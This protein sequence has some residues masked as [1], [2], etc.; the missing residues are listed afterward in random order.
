MCPAKVSLVAGGGGDGDGGAGAGGM[1]PIQSVLLLVV[2]VEV[3]S[4]KV[5]FVVFLH[6]FFF[7]LFW[8]VYSCAL[9]SMC[10]C[11]RARARVC[12]CVHMCV[13]VC[14]CVY[15]YVCVYTRAR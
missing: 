6:I 7:V 8:I 14:V 4:A 12:V 3:C 10:V 1:C 13:C 9:A 2:L 5:N 15:V 11:A